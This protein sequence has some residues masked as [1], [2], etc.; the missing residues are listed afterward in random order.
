MKIDP[1]IQSPGD[2]QSEVVSNTKKGSSTSTKTRA[3]STSSSSLGDTI[4]ISS[5]HAEAQQLTAQIAKVPEV[6]TERVE[7]LKT[8][9][10]KGEYQPE[11]GKIA[12]AMLAEQ[13]SKSAKA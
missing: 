4:Q 9:V 3:T 10:Q 7:P 8:A 5:R 2:P 11:S 12:D 13:T 1:R 6:R